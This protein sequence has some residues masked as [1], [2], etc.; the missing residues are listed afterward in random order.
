MRRENSQDDCEATDSMSPQSTRKLLAFTRMLKEIRAALSNST[1]EHVSGP[2]SNGFIE[3]LQDSVKNL[4]ASVPEASE[5]ERLAVF[6]GIAKELRL[7]NLCGFQERTQGE[8]P[9]QMM[10]YYYI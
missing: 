7:R 9:T 8:A 6:G 3:A 2:I 5:F 4:P 1:F 10:S